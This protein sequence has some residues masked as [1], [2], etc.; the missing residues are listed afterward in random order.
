M[1]YYLIYL[2]ITSII[3]FF[4]YVADKRKAKKGK[5]R[6]SEKALLGM[7]FLGGGVGGYFAM[8]LVRHKTK[9]W[10]FH[11]VNILGILWQVGLLIW[12]LLA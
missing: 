2:I 10:Y 4:L 7:S 9:H 12:W 11:V 5:W 3:T 1:K 6:V 8:H